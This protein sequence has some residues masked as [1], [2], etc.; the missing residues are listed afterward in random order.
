MMCQDVPTYG[1]LYFKIK[2]RMIKYSYKM[3]DLTA[4]TYKW[5]INKENGDK[6]NWLEA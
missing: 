4:G 6:N 3:N 1:G 2:V 5:D